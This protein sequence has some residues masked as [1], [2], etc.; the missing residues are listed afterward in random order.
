MELTLSRDNVLDTKL[1]AADGRCLYTITT[2]SKWR[3]LTT[4]VTK[5]DVDAA[6]PVVDVER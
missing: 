6:S 3:V 4:L 1:T 5:H 2:P